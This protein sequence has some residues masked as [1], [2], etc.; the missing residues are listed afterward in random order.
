MGR[1][2]GSKNKPRRLLLRR[3][4]DL[5]PGYH[6]VVEM[7]RLANDSTQ[8]LEV[9]FAANKEVARYVAPVLQAVKVSTDTAGGSGVLRV[10]A[11]PENIEEWRQR[12]AE[13]NAETEG[14]LIEHVPD[15]D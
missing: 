8:P 10:P 13:I 2:L 6:P 1:P 7:A 15:D 5:W 9:R 11:P 3:L 12:A 4:E 14:A